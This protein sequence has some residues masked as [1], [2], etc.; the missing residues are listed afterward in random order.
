MRNGIN[1]TVR[2]NREIILSA[3]VFR[4]PQILMLSGIGNREHLSTLNITVILDLPVGDNFQ[5]H[6]AVNPIINIYNY[7]YINPSNDMT[8]ENLYEYYVNSSGPLSLLSS[9]DT[10][11]S[12]RFNDDYE[13]PDFYNSV[14]VARFGNNLTEIVSGYDS[15]Y[16]NDWENYYRPLLGKSY[17]HISFSVYRYV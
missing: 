7:S 17:I 16:R 9:V 14:D 5:A 15:S 3:G 11:M 10:L 1:Y 4:S 6:V 2:A 13:W 8:V 12:T